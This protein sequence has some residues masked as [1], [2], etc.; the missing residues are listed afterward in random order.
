MI[1]DLDETLKKLLVEKGKLNAGE[2]DITFDQPNGEWAAG[3]SRPTL[4][5]WLFDVRENRELR[6]MEWEV[7]R[8]NDNRSGKLRLPPLRFDLT[9]LVTAWTRKVEDEHQLLWRALGALSQTRALDPDTCEGALRDQAYDIPVQVGQTSEAIQSMSDLWSVLDNEMRAGFLVKLTLA[10]EADRGFDAPLV[11][12]SRVSVGQA[13][14]PPRQEITVLDTVLEIPKRADGA[15]AGAKQGKA[16][17]GS[18]E[19]DG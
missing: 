12:E 2:I 1:Q 19:G 10:L 11:L 7:T 9:Y 18:K 15:A 13:E 8:T 3:L 14:E 17:R 4:N 5:C 16:K 6:S